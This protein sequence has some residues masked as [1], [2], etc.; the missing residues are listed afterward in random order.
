M[1]SGSLRM[2]YTVMRGLSEPNGSWKMNWM[3]RRNSIN[4]LL[5]ERQ[6]IDDL[7]AVVEVDRS[8]VGRERPH[9]DLRQGRLAAAALADQ[10]QALAAADLEA[11]VVDRGDRAVGAAAEEA[12]LAELKPLADVAHGQQ[13]AGRV[14]IG[15]PRLLGGQQAGARGLDFA[16]RHQP[17]AGFHVKARHGV[18]QRPQIGMGRP[19]EDVVERAALHDLAVIEDDDLFRHVGD[20][21]EV[22]GDDRERPCRARPAGPASASGSAPGSSRR[23][24]WSARRRSAAPAG[25]SAPSRSSPAGAARPTVRRDRCSGPWPDRGSRPAEA[26]PSPVRAPPRRSPCGA[27][28]ALRRSDCRPCGSATATSSAPER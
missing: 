9:D 24:P 2:S 8:G 13:R 23:A 28:A 1:T 18:Q 17:L 16:D 22:V 21:A 10:T 6:H 12:A 14:G 7:A 25:R 27:D 4:A 19:A 20:H 11:D 26:C 5:L 3:R 15:R